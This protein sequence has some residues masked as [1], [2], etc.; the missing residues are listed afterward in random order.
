M[1]GGCRRAL[2]GSQSGARCEIAEEGMEK[3]GESSYCGITRE[4]NLG[5]PGSW[6]GSLFDYHPPRFYFSAG[7]QRLLI[8]AMS[9]PNGTSQ[10]LAKKLG[11]SLPL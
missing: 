11:V 4:W 5:R 2:L 1:G 7:E 10:A 6:V 9:S 3:I 8:A